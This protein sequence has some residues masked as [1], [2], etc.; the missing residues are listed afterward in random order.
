MPTLSR[1]E[2]DVLE[3]LTTAIIVDQERMGANVRSTVGTATDANALLRLLFSRLGHAPHRAPDGVLVQHPDAQGQRRDDRRQGQG[4][5]DRRARRHLLRRHVPALRGDGLHQRHGPDPAVRRQQVPS[6]RRPHDPGLQHG[7]LV[8]PHLRGRRLRHG[9][10]DPRLH[11]EGARSPAPRGAD[12]D[13]RRRGQPDLR[14][15]DHEDPEV[16]AVE[17]HRHAPAARPRLRR[18]SCHVHPVPRVWRQPPQRTG[19]IL[20]DR[21]DQHRRRLRD[22]DR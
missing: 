3:G 11:P 19:P 7:R 14:G 1:P 9:Q 20:E 18:A 4:R 21:R 15:R 17:G 6:R 8:R 5:A 10:A 12:Q 22:A 2:V 13:Q 16:D